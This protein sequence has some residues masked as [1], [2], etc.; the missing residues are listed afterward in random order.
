MTK[1]MT[2][3]GLSG[4]HGTMND[5]T[6]I[7]S[8]QNIYIYVIIGVLNASEVQILQILNLEELCLDNLTHFPVNW[9]QTLSST[10]ASQ[11][12]WL[13]LE[14]IYKMGEAHTILLWY[15]RCPRIYRS[16]VTAASRSLAFAM[17]L[18]ASAAVVITWHNEI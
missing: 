10:N 16:N 4:Y 13:I 15:A 14:D 17:H 12:E 1:S 5:C 11:E 2:L 3:Q 6:N 9:E 18:N 8:K 7:P